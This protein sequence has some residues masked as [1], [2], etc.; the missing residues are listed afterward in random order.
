MALE[1]RLRPDRTYGKVD[2][3]YFF[4]TDTWPVQYCPVAN[5]INLVGK[6]ITFPD[7]AKSNA[8]AFSRG[9]IGG[10]LYGGCAS[11]V[12]IPFQEWGPADMVPAPTHTLADE[13]IGT[14]PAGT[15]NLIVQVKLARTTSPSQLGGKTIP[16]LP[17]EGDWV[18]CPGGGLPIEKLG[19]MA[20]HLSFL[21]AP[22]SNPDGT[23]NVLMRRK[24][25]IFK[26]KYAYWRAG[27]DASNSGWTYGGANGEFGHVVALI[28]SLGPVYDPSGTLL[29]RG[30][31]SACSLTDNT[32]YT[33]VYTGDI[34]IIPGRDDIEPSNER[35][36]P[37]LAF[38][39]SDY[40]LT[41]GSTQTVAGLFFGAAAPTRRVVAAISAYRAGGD[42]A[43]YSIS[44]VTIGG[45]AATRVVERDSGWDTTGA[46]DQ[47]SIA[48]L[49]IADVPAGTS[50]DVVIN[51]T[52]SF[53]MVMVNVYALYDLVSAAPDATISSGSSN[54]YYG[55]PTAANGVAIACAMMG[56]TS[57]DFYG[58]ENN[59]AESF[60]DTGPVRTM[61]GGRAFQY[62]TGAILSIQSGTVASGTSS[63]AAWVA[64]SFH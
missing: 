55:L 28:Q 39:A 7:L 59:Y 15:D 17:T 33:S 47:T 12:C 20:R 48:A 56:H 5:E 61:I 13:V 42:G 32:D 27:N 40:T 11:Y 37:L 43:P 51:Y 41:D 8:Y 22:V 36:G 1:S 14:V 53:S 49:F 35:T 6:V 10:N 3:V 30:G 18:N 24:Q 58:I 2:G 34:R 54:V 52:A 21:L 64:A 9:L 60:T 31:A 29:A 38:C 44:S 25:S 4:D 19:P 45:V 26:R 50:G 46:N 63:V 16:V 57:P 23:I 62:T